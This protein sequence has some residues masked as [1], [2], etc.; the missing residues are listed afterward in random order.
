MAFPLPNRHVVSLLLSAALTLSACMQAS[1]DIDLS[2]SRITM[3]A[4]YRATYQSEIQ[5]PPQRV[6]HAWT[7]DLTR[8]DGQPVEN[9][10]L[11]VSGG[12][13][14]HGHGLPTE[15][16][17]TK[18]LGHGRYLIEGLKFTMPGWWEV[19]LDIEAAAGH[20]T[21]TFNLSL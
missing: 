13:P 10:R 4:L 7:I 15:P 5:P 3:K 21:V 8:P 2:N 12:M 18:E 19:S 16:R 20:D 1:D 6:I 9:A 11:S 17:M 14:Q